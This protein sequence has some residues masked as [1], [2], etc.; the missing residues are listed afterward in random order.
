MAQCKT[1][2]PMLEN[3]GSIPGLGAKIPTYLAAKK[4]NKTIKQKQYCKKFNKNLKKVLGTLQGGQVSRR[5]GIHSRNSM[6]RDKVRTVTSHIRKMVIADITLSLVSVIRCDTGTL[7]PDTLGEARGGTQPHPDL[8]CPWMN[9]AA[10]TPAP[11]QK[12][13][14]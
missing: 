4:K 3:A 11:G 5:S 14:K 8:S 13:Y 6:P 1:S 7:C 2:P 9:Q 12:A 10:N